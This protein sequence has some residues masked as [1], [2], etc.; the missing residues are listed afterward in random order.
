MS[1]IVVSVFRMLTAE[2][3]EDASRQNRNSDIGT[4]RLPL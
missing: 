1:R 3:G 2:L 4:Q